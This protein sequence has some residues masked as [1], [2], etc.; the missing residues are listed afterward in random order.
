MS[1]EELQAF[2]LVEIQIILESNNKSLSE[3]SCMPQPD[4]SLVMSTQNRLIFDELNYDKHALGLESKQL[5][6]RMTSEQH[7]VYMTI[8]NRVES[9]EAGLFF[10][11]DTVALVKHIYG[12]LY[13]RH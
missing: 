1:P 9:G 12:E 7:H 8:I 11:M 2:A 13:L 3:F 5:L 6:S 4:M 10:F